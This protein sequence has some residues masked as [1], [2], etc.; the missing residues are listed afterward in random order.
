MIGDKPGEGLACGNHGLVYGYQEGFQKAL[1][2][3][4]QLLS[5]GKKKLEKG[6]GKEKLM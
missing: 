5:I 3:G 6:T 1:E 2:Y 4:K